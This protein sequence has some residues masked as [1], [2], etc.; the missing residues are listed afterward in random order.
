M[1]KILLINLFVLLY[2]PLLAQYSITASD[3]SKINTSSGDL[4]LL[5][6]ASRSDGDAFMELESTLSVAFRH[7]YSTD[8]V[9]AAFWQHAKQEDSGKF[10]YY[11]RAHVI[12]S[13]NKYEQI[14]DNNTRIRDTYFRTI[15]LFRTNNE[16]GLNGDYQLGALFVPWNYYHHKYSVDIA[17][18]AM[19]SYSSWDMVADE[20]V[21]IDKEKYDFIYDNIGVNSKGHKNYLNIY[22]A[23][24][25]SVRYSPVQNISLY[26]SMTMEL[27]T[28]S[29]F[30][31]TI[32]D[33]Y[34]DL[35]KIH[36]LN[37]FELGLNIKISNALSVDF[38][39]RW[40]FERGVPTRYTDDYSWYFGAGLGWNFGSA[41]PNIK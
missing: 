38:D 37:R 20:Y 21:G 10:D 40:D 2:F 17:F 29:P 9:Y 11:A 30:N 39:S 14:D 41:S 33:K 4:S 1:K 24:T 31:K 8:E 34:S 6:H 25:A 26:G 7:V 18:G 3:T 28:K 36:P 12:Y 5:M 22:P 15:A 32:T 23:A 27:Q 13:P 19:L 35:K 16:R